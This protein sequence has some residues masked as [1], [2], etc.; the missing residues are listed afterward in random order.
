M[1]EMMFV[2]VTNDMAHI[3]PCTIKDAHAPTCDGHE[4]RA[5]DTHLVPTGR[6][7]RGCQPREATQGFLCWSCFESAR[8]AILESGE[9]MDALS[10]YPRLMQAESVGGRTAADG[11]VNIAATTLVLDELNQYLR[12]FPGSTEQWAVTTAGAQDAVRFTRLFNTAKMA[13]PIE[14]K[15]R[16]LAMRC[17]ECQLKSIMWTPP[18]RKFDKVTANCQNTQCGHIIPEDDIP[19][20][21]R[22]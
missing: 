15:P 9:L 4:R 13:H 3:T 16:R 6:P 19:E 21:V 7:C 2:C 20:E 17:P 11:H 18:V 5:N 12:S 10:R 14:D 8:K 22:L 1:T